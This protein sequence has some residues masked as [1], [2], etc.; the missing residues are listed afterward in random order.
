S[1]TYTG[2]N[3][4]IGKQTIAVVAVAKNKTYGDVDPSLTYTFTPVLVTGDSFTGDISR[5][6]GE[7]IGNYPISQGSLALNN[8]YVLTYTGSSLSIDKKTIAVGAV[9]K[10]KIYGDADPV[11]TYTFTPVLATGDSFTGDISRALGENIG[12]YAIGQGTLALNS[13]YTLNYTGADLTIG[14]QTIAVVAVA[15]NKTYGQA[16]PALTYTFTPALVTGDSFTGYI[17]RALGENIGNYAIGQGTL[18]LNSNYTL[19]YTGADLTIGKQTITVVAVAKNR[20]YGETDPALTYTFSPDLIIGDSFNGALS[21]ATGE[22]VA[23]YVINKN[24][25]ALSNNYLLNFVSGNFVINKKQLTITADNKSKI[26][27]DANPILTA[28]YSGFVGSE[29]AAVMSNSVVLNTT[30]TISSSPGIYTIDVSGATASNYN[31][32]F[33]QGTLTV[34]PNS[35]IITFGTLADK[36]STDVIFSLTASSSAGLTIS[37]SSHDPTVAR[38]INGNQVEILKPGTVNITASQAGNTNYATALAVTQTLKINDNSAF[39]IAISSSKGT[40]ISLGETT[41]LTAR[42]ALIYQWATANGVISDQNAASLTV[43]PSANTVYTVTGT[44]QY[45]RSITQTIEIKVTA[46]L[47]LITATNILSPNGDGMND[48]WV[49][50]NIDM[51]PNNVVTIVDRVGRPVFKIKG[52]KNNWDA[53]LNGAQLQEGTYYYVIDFGILGKTSKKGFITVIR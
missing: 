22:N 4:S 10:N 28:S 35:Q 2:A 36:L 23:S 31:I 19:N 15:K 40:T 49:V 38:I 17:N 8:N 50:Y 43:R 20:V 53:T 42:G 14:K 24:T 44:N 48:V 52:Y 45:G 5:A 13:N 11:F 6:L 37:Y 3:L 9:A 16:D 27:S 29:T 26:F 41:V 1:L 51:Y 25:L 32:N 39:E 21:R 7:S 47:Q 18:A 46:D 33:V 12:N 34:A 30:A